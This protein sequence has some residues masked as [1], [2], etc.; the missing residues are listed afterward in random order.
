[1]STRLTYLALRRSYR[2]ACRLPA[3]RGSVEDGQVCVRARVSACAALRT[4]T[5]QWDTLETTRRNLWAEGHRVYHRPTGISVWRA[6]VSPAAQR[7]FRRE[8]SA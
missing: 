4:F 2:V 1:M 6:Y 8:V 5:N 7:F 3:S